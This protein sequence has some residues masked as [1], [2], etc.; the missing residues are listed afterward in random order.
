MFELDVATMATAFRHRLQGS[1]I[2]L[3]V[4]YISLVILSFVNLIALEAASWRYYI[5]F[6]VILAISCVTA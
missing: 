5:M 6:L 3:A 1:S 4:L 2:E